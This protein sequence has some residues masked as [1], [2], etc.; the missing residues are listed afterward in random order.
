MKSASSVDGDC[1]ESLTVRFRRIVAATK[2]P[3]ARPSRRSYS[4]AARSYAPAS[5]SALASEYNLSGDQLDSMSLPVDP[6]PATTAAANKSAMRI[7]ECL[8]FMN[9]SR[10]SKNEPG[11]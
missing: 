8:Q 11:L 2:A 1:W 10:L 7:T 4:L 9:R 5:V 6:H 3:D